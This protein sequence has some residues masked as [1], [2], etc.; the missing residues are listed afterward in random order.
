MLSIAATVTLTS[1]AALRP[2]V[3]DEELHSA[4]FNATCDYHL[5]FGETLSRRPV[6]TRRFTIDLEQGTWSEGDGSNPQK[7]RRE[8]GDRI[9]RSYG[10]IEHQVRQWF[11]LS[12][13]RS[14]Q[15][16]LLGDPALLFR[17]RGDCRREPSTAPADAAGR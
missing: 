10:S 17:W 13:G 12:S 8:T 5:R 6:L 1:C 11:D 16:E 7:I 4:K 9:S 14:D 2:L 3:A 15:Q